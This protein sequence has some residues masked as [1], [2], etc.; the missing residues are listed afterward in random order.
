MDLFTWPS[1]LIKSAFPLAT[2]FVLQ[3]VF[4]HFD[5]AKTDSVT[6]LLGKYSYEGYLVHPTMLMG[7]IALCSD[8]YSVLVNV[9]IFVVSVA[10]LSVILSFVSRKIVQVF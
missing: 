5:I 3:S 10:I 7:P 2:L 1:M 9:V 6:R 4:H 8:D